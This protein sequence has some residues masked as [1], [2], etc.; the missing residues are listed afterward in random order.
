MVGFQHLGCSASNESFFPVLMCNFHF[1]ENFRS[2]E[3][4]HTPCEKKI[5]VHNSTTNE[6][7]APVLFGSWFQREPSQFQTLLKN[8][9]F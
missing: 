9:N 4:S 1:V 3:K 8:F 5:A 6:R 7:H 2:K